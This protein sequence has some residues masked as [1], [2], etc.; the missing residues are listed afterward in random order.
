MQP[1]SQVKYAKIST[2]KSHSKAPV[3]ADV[4]GL[5]LFLFRLFYTS[6][7]ATTKAPKI[8]FPL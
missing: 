8:L 5:G 3:L 2:Y 1:P 6:R 7:S 4:C